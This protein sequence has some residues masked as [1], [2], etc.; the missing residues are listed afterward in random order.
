MLLSASLILSACGDAG[1]PPAGT[2]GDTAASTPAGADTGADTAVTPEAEAEATEVIE[3]ET[4]LITETEVLTE[5]EVV[6]DVDVTEVIT[7]TIVSTDTVEAGEGGSEV[8][9]ETE[10]MTDAEELEDT[11]GTGDSEGVT[12]TEEMTGTE[13]LDDSEGMTE[14]GSTGTGTAG[15]AGAAG[16]MM[17]VSGSQ[18]QYIRGST[19]LDYDF[20]NMDGEVSGDLEDLL[21]DLSTGRVLFASIEYGGVLDLGDKDIVVPL[22]AFTTGA[23]GELVLNIDEATLENYPDVGNNWPDLNDPA[24][25]DDV[26]G[27]WTETGIEQGAGFDE[28]T[29]TVAWASDLMDDQVADLGAGAGSVID[30][31]VN[32]GTAQAP[33]LIVDYGEGLDTDPY[34]IPLAAYDTTNREAGLVYGP[35]FT[36]DLLENAPR[37]DQ[38]LYPEGSTLDSD[39]GDQIESAW[40]DM[41]FSNDLNND[42][43]ID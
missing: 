34:I 23:E 2:T 5:T 35:D 31:L 19:L 32:I 21:I 7:E 4:G 16:S 39:F 24:W 22:N 29:T 27:F 10:V 30:I 3:T 12:G 8:I 40:N 6:T 26:L 9:T 43:E 20:E 17:G 33:Y 11:E 28:P 1:A 36:P 37:F 14:T 25:D 41:G 18:D 15:A 38:D 42:S 13:G